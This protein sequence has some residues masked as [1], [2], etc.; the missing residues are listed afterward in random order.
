MASNLV[1]VAFDEGKFTRT[2]GSFGNVV[3]QIYIQ[4]DASLFG[5]G[6]LIF[7]GADRSCLLGGCAASI[8]DFRFGTDSSFQNTAEFIVAASGVLLAIQLGHA[9]SI[10]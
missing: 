7:R 6:V 4:S 1:L 10:K 5:V 2:L 9:N 8:S 3:P